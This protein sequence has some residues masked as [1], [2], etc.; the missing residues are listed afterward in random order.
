MDLLEQSRA[1]FNIYIPKKEDN[2]DCSLAKVIN[3]YPEKDKMKILFLR[4][5][6][7]VYMFGQKKVYIKVESGNEIKVRVGGGFISGQEFIE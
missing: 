6:E 1:Q 3:N 2:I 5:S 4:E 7:G